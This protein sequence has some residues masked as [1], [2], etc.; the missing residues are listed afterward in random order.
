M[1]PTQI[2]R[3]GSNVTTF[4]FYYS[5]TITY[6]GSDHLPYAILAIVIFT[7]FVC[8]PT[9][10]FVIYPCQLFQKCLFA[11]PLNWYV[12]HALVDSFQGCYKDGT[13]PGT[14]NC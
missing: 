11:F 2:Y 10:I 8:I 14:F 5:P 12:L 13:E 4:G 1:I 3:L 9:L 6:F 7:C